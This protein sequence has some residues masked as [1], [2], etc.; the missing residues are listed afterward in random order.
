MFWTLGSRRAEA[1]AK[2]LRGL[3]YGQASQPPTHFDVPTGNG[4]M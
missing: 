2:R 1:K 3:L 4:R